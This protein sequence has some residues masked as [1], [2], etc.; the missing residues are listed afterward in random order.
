MG[1]PVSLP[2]ASNIPAPPGRNHGSHHKSR[3]CLVNVNRDFSSGRNKP[4]SKDLG[5]IEEV[6]RDH[7]STACEN[8]NGH[9]GELRPDS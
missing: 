8:G 1:P 4:K 2:L 5:Y 6:P 9:P 7:L 3:D